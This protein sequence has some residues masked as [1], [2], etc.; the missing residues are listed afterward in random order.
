MVKWR[1]QVRLKAYVFDILLLI[2]VLHQN[3]VFSRM[4]LYWYF[5]QDKQD[6]AKCESF[7]KSS[8]FGLD[9]WVIL[10][11]FYANAE[12]L[13]TIIDIYEKSIQD[14]DNNEFI[15][16]LAGVI[17]FNSQ[18]LGKDIVLSKNS[19]TNNNKVTVDIQFTISC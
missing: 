16:K 9:T 14:L 12:A 2:R 11:Q 1:R 15:K 3:H 13:L 17:T 7:M 5:T 18:L 6:D 10:N 19:S 8:N 4:W